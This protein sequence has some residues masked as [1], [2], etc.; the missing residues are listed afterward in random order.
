MP[1]I[2]GRYLKNLHN[3]QNSRLCPGQFE[4]QYAVELKMTS[5][6]LAPDVPVTEL[7]ASF[8]PNTP[9]GQARDQS[10]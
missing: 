7:R 5:A 2:N 8:Q 10:Q 1:P 4:V 9:K 6:T 3:Q